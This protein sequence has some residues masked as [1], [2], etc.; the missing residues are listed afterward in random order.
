LAADRDVID[1]V[2]KARKEMETA[3]AKATK[4]MEDTKKKAADQ[5]MEK[6]KKAKREGQAKLDAE[7]AKIDKKT[8]DAADQVAAA[9]QRFSDETTAKWDMVEADRKNAEE[10]AT[11]KGDKDTAAASSKFEQD[12]EKILADDQ[13]KKVKLK[14]IDETEAD[15]KRNIREEAVAKLDK[16]TDKAAAARK[17]LE[18]LRKPSIPPGYMLVPEPAVACTNPPALPGSLLAEKPPLR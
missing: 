2:A 17:V 15:E 9:R 7:E 3:T 4:T 6:K 14:T 16:A 10:E 8:P 1:A 5:E 18:P 12:M 11:F 13:A